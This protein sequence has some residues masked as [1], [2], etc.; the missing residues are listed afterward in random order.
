MVSMKKWM[1]AIALAAG[2]LGLGAS[3]ASAARIGF[4]VYVG[5]PAYVPPCPGPGY[6]WVAGSYANGYWAPGFWRAPEPRH[7]VVVRP[8]YGW[9]HGPVSDHRF[10]DHRFDHDRFRR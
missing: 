9:A 1:L 4:G 5:A 2:T 10:N 8:G 7:G 6:I 3:Q